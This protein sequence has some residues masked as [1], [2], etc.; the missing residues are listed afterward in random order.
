MSGADG[1]R[2]VPGMTVPARLYRATVP[3]ML[4]LEVHST[5]A[6]EETIAALGAA[7]APGQPDPLL[8]ANV[9]LMDRFKLFPQVEL[10]IAR[11]RGAVLTGRVTLEESE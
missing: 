10:A 2:D 1:K 5:M 6:P 4:E 3:V 11:T 8:G 9:K 7:F